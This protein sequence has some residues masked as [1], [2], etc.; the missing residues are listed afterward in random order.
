MPGQLTGATQAHMLE[1][2]VGTS[3]VQEGQGK[4]GPAAVYKSA[5]KK[6][7]EVWLQFQV[8][9]NEPPDFLWDFAVHFG[10]VHVSRSCTRP[11]VQNLVPQREINTPS[12]VRKCTRIYA[13][14]F[15]SQHLKPINEDSFLR[16]NL[17]KDSMGSKVNKT[18]QE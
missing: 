4:T 18:R 13:K 8:L 7:P 14:N 9:T 1:T 17:V 3:P 2:R 6:A 16:I 5:A 11:V 15:R 12:M 10:R